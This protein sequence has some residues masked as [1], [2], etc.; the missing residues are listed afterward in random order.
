VPAR[1]LSEAPLR[2][3]EELHGAALASPSRRFLALAFDLALIA[4]PNLMAVTLVAWLSLRVTDP[5]AFRALPVVY[6]QRSAGPASP[7]ALAAIAPLLVRT[8]AEGIPSGLDQAVHAN[9]KARAAE[10]L[11]PYSFDFMVSIG[12]NEDERPLPAGTIRVRVAD[13]IPRLGRALA[14]YGLMGLY[15]GLLTA[16]RRGQ[17]LGKRLFGIRVARLDGHRLSL[18]ESLE[19]FVGYLHI[20]GSLGISIVDLW[21]DPNR[22]MP[23]DRVAHTVVVRVPPRRREPAVAKKAEAPVA[24][25]TSPAAAPAAT[26][27]DTPASAAPAGGDGDSFSSAARPAR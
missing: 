9:D 19:R 25:P 27:A 6:Q 5:P 14:S 16:G 20:P 21:R 13:F 18:V 23:H 12:E 11:R 7:E 2:V 4:I 26:T 1:T 10:L 3:T 24:A 22:R 15:F 8:H 17:T